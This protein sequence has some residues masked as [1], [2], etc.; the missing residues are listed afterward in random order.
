M[1]L[2]RFAWIAVAACGAAA[3][4]GVYAPE[5]ADRWLPAAGEFAHELHDRIWTPPAQTASS[6]SARVK[7]PKRPALRRSSS[8]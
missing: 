2:A 5:A 8:P 3:A 7:P 1:R 4:Y 6:A